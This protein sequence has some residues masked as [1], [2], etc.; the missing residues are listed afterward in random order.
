MSNQFHQ[1][2]QF[3]LNVV[4]RIKGKDKVI[5]PNETMIGALANYI[6]LK[7]DNFQ[8]MNANFGILPQLDKKIKDK[9]SRYEKLANRALSGLKQIKY[10]RCRNIKQT[11]FDN[12]M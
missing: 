8:P 6:S 9:K 2:W 11:K 5:F 3:G 12:F 4:N 10:V 7:N 1:E